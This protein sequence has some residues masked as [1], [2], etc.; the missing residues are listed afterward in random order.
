VAAFAGRVVMMKDGRVKSDRRQ[1]PRD[2][3]QALAQAVTQ[4]QQ[5]VASEEAAAQA[6][7]QRR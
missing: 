5:E 3:R 7:G 1:E 2:A 4:R 6:E